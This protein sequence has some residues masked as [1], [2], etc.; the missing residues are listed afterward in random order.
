MGFGAVAL[1]A[2]TND[3][4]FTGEE[5]WNAFSGQGQEVIFL[6]MDGGP[7]QVDT[8]DSKPLLGKYDGQD[9]ARGL[10]VSSRRSSTTSASRWLAVEVS[11][12]MASAARPV[13]ELFPHVAAVR[14]RP[15]LLFAR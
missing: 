1:A 2:L 4:A 11:S 7:S 9:P 5:S 15:A 14:R 8:F 3:K 10:Q 13:S 6:Y 12:S